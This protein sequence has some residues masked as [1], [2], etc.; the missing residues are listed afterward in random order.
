MAGTMHTNDTRSI[1]TVLENAG[2]KPYQY[3][4]SLRLLV[5]HTLVPKICPKCNGTGEIHEEG[6]KDTSCAECYGTGAKGREVIYEIAFLVPG[7]VPLDANPAKDFD[8]LIKSGAI[9]FRSKEEIAK[10]KFDLGLIDE[11]VYRS[12]RGEHIERIKSLIDST[13]E[14]EYATAQ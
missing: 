6:I 7:K 1:F 4:P 9:I 13:R 11:D 10:R 12:F 2:L 8:E 3:L 5:H 14:E